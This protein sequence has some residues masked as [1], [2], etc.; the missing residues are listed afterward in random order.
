MKELIA[1]DTALT[2][3]VLGARLLIQTSTLLIVI[4]LLGSEQ[5]GTF[6]G[7]AAFAVILGTLSCFGTQ[8]LL[9]DRIANDHAHRNLILQFAVPVTTLTGTLLLG[10][11]LIISPILFT[12]AGYD[13]GTVMF[14][15]FLI[16]VSEVLLQPLYSLMVFE[17]HALGKIAFSQTLQLVPLMFRL[18]AISLIF[19]FGVDDPILGVAMGYLVSYLLA[20]L[21]GI[22]LLPEAWPSPRSWR[23]P[24]AAEFQSAL[25]YAAVNF[26][27]AGPGELDK[28]LAAVFLPN[29]TASLYNAGARVIG[30]ITL[31]VTAMI[32]SVLP[33]LFRQGN[34]NSAG[35]NSLVFKMYVIACV[36]GTL[37]SAIVWIAAPDLE[38]IF[39]DDFRG[40]GEAVRWLCLIIPAMAA[41]LVGGNLIMTLVNSW[42]RFGYECLGLCVL[43]FTSFILASE[44]GLHGMIAA[45]ILAEWLTATL[46]AVFLATVIK[47]DGLLEK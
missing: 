4:L 43:G 1:K 37:L 18:S 30:A 5:F 33:R 2:S 25:G 9:L 16:G 22:W 35:T 34:K 3:I 8:I 28:T 26:T 19:V 29:V 14:L 17:H 44:Y 7:I 47:K 42:F 20:F 41:R 11:F 40:I 6:A 13:S 45:A 12:L 10:L 24:T 27:R 36:Y 32:L 15:I 39:A 23:L 31:P 38:M 21:V 46:G